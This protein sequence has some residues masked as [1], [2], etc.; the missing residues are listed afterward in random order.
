MEEAYLGC[1]LVLLVSE[2]LNQ[3]LLLRRCH[4]P[5]QD[6]HGLT[7]VRDSGRMAA[8]KNAGLGRA[9]LHRVTS[10]LAEQA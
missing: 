2:F 4:G 8:V 1:H 10:E 9:K 3:L 7:Q 5:L 6:H